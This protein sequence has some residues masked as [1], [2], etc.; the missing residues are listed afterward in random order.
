MIEYYYKEKTKTE[1]EKIPEFIKGSW[2]NVVN[3]SKEEMDF[4]RV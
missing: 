3:P 1:I 4:S 2:V